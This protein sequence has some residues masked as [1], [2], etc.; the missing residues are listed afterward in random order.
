MIPHCIKMSSNSFVVLDLMERLLVAE[1]ACSILKYSARV[2]VLSYISP[3]LTSMWKII[4][5]N[6]KIAWSHMIL[7]Y[8][9]D[10][11]HLCYVCG[12]NAGMNILTC[13][14]VPLLSSIF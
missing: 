14:L 1:I 3:L 6:V 2:N 5:N 4:I 10:L 8:L 11:K 13:K 12:Y 9:S 7:L